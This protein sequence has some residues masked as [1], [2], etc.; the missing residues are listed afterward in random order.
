[1]NVIRTE[2]IELNPNDTLSELCH[3]SKNL[4][5]EANYTLVKLYIKRYQKKLK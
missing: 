5:N 3:Y 4:W 1:M 2:Q